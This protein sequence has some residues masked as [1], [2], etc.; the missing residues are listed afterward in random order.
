MVLLLKDCDYYLLQRSSQQDASDKRAGG[1]V[2]TKTCGCH[3]GGHR[4][5]SCVDKTGYI[6]M[7]QNTHIQTRPLISTAKQ[8]VWGMQ[9]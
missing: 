6:H 9:Q 1:S 5:A 2:M 3:G 7:K 4:S 8:V